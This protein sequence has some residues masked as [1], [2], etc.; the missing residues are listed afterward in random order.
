LQSAEASFLIIGS[1]I[2][3][4]RA[5][6]ALAGAGDV[7]ILTKAGPREGS[8]GYAQGGIAA[9]IGP[10][11]S[12]A[13]HLADTLA[14]GDGLCDERAVAVLVEEGPRYVRELIAWGAGFDL[15][16]D[17]T[18]AL[19][20]EG[21]HS[22]RRVLHAHDAT[23][24]EIGRVLWDRV[25]RIPNVRVHAHARAT[26]AIVADGRCIGVRFLDED[27]KIASAHARY[28]LLATGGAGQVYRETT[29]PPVATGD[30]VM[31]AYCAGAAVADLEFIQFHP[32]VLQMSWQPRFLLSEALRGEGARLVNADGEPF[33]TRVDP[34]G[35]LAPRDRVSRAIARE[36]QRTGGDVFL[37]LEHLDPAFVHE[38]FPL[39]SEAC[40]RA[41]L[42]LARD[43]I[44]VGPAAHYAMGGIVTDLDGRTTIQGLFAAGEVAC[45]G[46][47]GANR[48]A[49]NSLLEGLV[50]GARAGLAM[51]QAGDASIDPEALRG[52]QNG[53]KGD[54][55][56]FSQKMAA[57][58]FLSKKTGQPGQEAATAQDVQDLM[59][60]NV[61]LF[62]DAAG[63]N[64]AVGVLEDGWNHVMDRID[65]DAASMT[66]EDWRLAS[67]TTVGRL[68]ARA[69]WRR[70]ESR[71]GHYRLDHPDRDDRHWKRRIM[72][73]RP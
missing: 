29:N 45:T 36:A 52:L 53:E 38:R 9:A 2:A 72:E 61:G 24:R 14:A 46:V 43:R 27:G 59:W 69:A 3:A 23:G 48:L 55:R 64:K 13:R 26:G 62:R 58:P 16:A 47:H 51:R 19:A 57:A 37:T 28:T 67:L 4:L 60:R 44:P 32:T 68:V 42:D 31:I 56:L 1:G 73:T 8:T 30:G 25:S 12:P 20:I 6:I 21:A 35:D 5:A 22:V 63:L 11:D 10:D 71:G 7:L 54:N 33:M 39:I 15:S 70:E 50:F 40:R 34:M 41:G 18:P 65:E 66:S 49:S 17:G